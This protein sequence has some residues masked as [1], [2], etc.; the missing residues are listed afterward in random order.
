V[1]LCGSTSGLV[2]ALPGA[3]N[4]SLL[5]ERFGADNGRIAR[6][7]GAFPLCIPGRP[8]AF[9]LPRKVQKSGL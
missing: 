3:S 5:A 6:H 7:D 8:P 1:W 2:A 9:T 4:V